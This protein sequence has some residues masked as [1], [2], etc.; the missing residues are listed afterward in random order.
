M[1]RD[2]L[3]TLEIAMFV[4]ATKGGNES[5]VFQIEA[6]FKCHPYARVSTTMFIQFGSYRKLVNL[7]LSAYAE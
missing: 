1:N 7:A 3:F 6:I 4:N 2:Q 5:F